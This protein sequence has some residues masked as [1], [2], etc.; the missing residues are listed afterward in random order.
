LDGGAGVDTADYSPASTAVT[1]NLVT[2]AA[3]GAE[4]NDVLANI[5]NVTG[6]AFI[7][8]ITGN[9]ASNVLLGMDG[10]DVLVGGL[11]ND[12][13]NGGL[14]TQDSVEYTDATGALVVNL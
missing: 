1:V 6:G 14:G 13:L 12:V 7:D 8:P 4:G 2:G 5:E 3:S 9:S 10:D 11:A